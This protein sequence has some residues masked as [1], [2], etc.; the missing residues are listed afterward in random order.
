MYSK[1]L[2]LI[3]ELEMVI[4]IKLTDMYVLNSTR[5]WDNKIHNFYM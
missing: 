5:L 2:E 3:L 1:L 4:V